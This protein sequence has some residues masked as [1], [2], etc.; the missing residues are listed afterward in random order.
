MIGVNAGM[1]QIPAGVGPAKGNSAYSS[2]KMAQIKMVEFLAAENPDMFIASVHPG[3]FATDLMTG[4]TSEEQKEGLNDVIDDGE[5]Y[6]SSL[7]ACS[8]S[9]SNSLFLSGRAATCHSEGARELTKAIVK[10][11]A[12]FILWMT[13]P[14][15]NS[16]KA[17]LH[18]RSGTWTSS[19]T[20]RMRSRIRRC[21]HQ[22][23]W[24]G[25]TCL[26]SRYERLSGDYLDNLFRWCGV[27]HIDI[28]LM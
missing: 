13:S 11:S 24:G 10:L 18:G 1:I 9:F 17:N 4:G 15:A 22:I 28:E 2:S 20:E 14:E 3:I 19:K 21:W 12:H 7:Y 26:G 8:N 23:S 25:L 5:W 16:C 6:L 27:M